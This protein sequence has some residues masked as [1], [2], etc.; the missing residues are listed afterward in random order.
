MHVADLTKWAADIRSNDPDRLIVLGWTVVIRRR[1]QLAAGN[2][3]AG[4]GSRGR[5]RWAASGDGDSGG[6]WWMERSWR[7][8]E[9]PGSSN[10]G[11]AVD[12]K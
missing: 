6:R 10:P 9:R 3:V 7:R 2:G 8:D 11:L 12:E 4:A 1:M 5:W